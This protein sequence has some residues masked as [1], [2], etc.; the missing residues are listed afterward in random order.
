MNNRP[1]A[2]C[3][4]DSDL[5]KAWTSYQATDEFKDTLYWATTETLMRKERAQ[6]LNVS[7]EANVMN[8]VDREQRVK[9]QLWAAF[10]A[11]FGAAGGKVTF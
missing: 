11:G 9:G 5:M 4:P 1:M 10:M 2:P 8:S 7:P 3:P 6:E